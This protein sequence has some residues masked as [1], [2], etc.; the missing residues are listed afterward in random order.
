LEKPCAKSTTSEVVENFPAFASRTRKREGSLVRRDGVGWWLGEGCWGCTLV[1]T[2]YT[3]HMRQG[4][5]YYD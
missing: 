1:W 2:Y 3:P 5:V 4:T